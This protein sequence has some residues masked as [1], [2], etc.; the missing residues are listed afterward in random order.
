MK[1]KCNLPIHVIR[2]C[3]NTTGAK[4][5]N[6]LK[7][8]RHHSYDSFFEVIVIKCAEQTSEAA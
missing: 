7:D 4:G 5:N 6:V 8:I 1:Q 3:V 2:F